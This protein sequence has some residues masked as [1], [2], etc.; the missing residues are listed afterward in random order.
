[1]R[2]FP[3]PVS[4]LEYEFDFAGRDVVRSTAGETRVT[5]EGNFEAGFYVDDLAIGRPFGRHLEPLLADWV[6]VALAAYVAD[7][8]SPRRDPKG[9][10]RAFQWARRLAL[11][12]PVREP[13]AWRRAEVSDALR[14]TLR[15]ITDDEWDFEFVPRRAG[16]DSRQ[17]YL[18]ATPPSKPVRA[19]L[20]SGGLDSFS[21]AARQSA[22]L[23]DHSFVFVSGASNA[24]QKVTQ[25]EQIGAIVRRFGREVRHVTVPFGIRWR[26][27]SHEGVEESSQRTR[28][29]LFPTIGAV[30]ALTAG[31]GELYIYENGIGAINLPYDATQLGTSNSRASH[32]ITLLRMSDFAGLLT[33]KPFAFINPFLFETKGEMCR[34]PSVRA[35]APHIPATFSCDGF[36][37][38][39][40][41]KPQC[42]TCT[43]CLLRRLSLEAAGLS[44][45]DPPDKY[46]CD[47]SDRATR[48]SQRQL[49]NLKAMEWQYQKIRQRLAAKGPWQS[50][51]TEFPE[52]QSVASEMAARGGPAGEVERRLL[53][54]YARYASEWERFS[55][56]RRLDARARAA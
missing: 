3:T 4:P 24:R 29:F 13:D 36:P 17:A 39:V 16:R 8:L 18:F 44:S 37:V 5:G 23:S 31:G 22:E 20:Y 28:G 52:L 25:R 19:A 14:E 15:H 34:H 11:R 26:G 21:G 47:L 7:R 12:I 33:G 46:L 10:Q 40:R 6:D 32:P 48:A 56:R 35:L 55:A 2:D 49:Q 42:G 50:M 54:L 27:R 51:I 43:S 38:Q 41:N 53:R 45:F 1:M 9:Q 30:T